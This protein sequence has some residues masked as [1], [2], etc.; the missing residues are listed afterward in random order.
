MKCAVSC[1]TERLW[2]LFVCETNKLPRRWTTLI[3]ALIPPS[4]CNLLHICCIL[5]QHVCLLFVS[6]FV[7]SVVHGFVEKSRSDRFHWIHRFSLNLGQCNFCWKL[8]VVSR[9]EGLSGNRSFISNEMQMKKQ[10]LII[11]DKNSWRQDGWEGAS[12]GR[13]W[14]AGAGRSWRRTLRTPGE[15]V[16]PIGTKV[17]DLAVECGSNL[18]SVQFLCLP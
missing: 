5:L 4:L 12:G 11:S 1:L 8:I 6:L 18:Y 14:R 9:A 13:R 10:N 2:S 7:E 17:T 15:R 3:E 16:F